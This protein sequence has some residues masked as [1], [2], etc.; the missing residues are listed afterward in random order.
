[1]R[2]PH[3]ILSAFIMLA[4]GWATLTLGMSVTT[5]VAQLMMVFFMSTLG[6]YAV[7]SAIMYRSSHLLV[8]L[9]NNI[10]DEECRRDTHVLRDYLHIM[11]GVAIVSV[12]LL[13]TFEG[14]RHMAPATVSGV[15]V[16]NLARM[17]E[18][19]LFGLC[20]LNLVYLL[21]LFRSLV[22]GMVQ[23]AMTRDTLD[24]NKRIVEAE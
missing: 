17:M 2:T 24:E 22:Q 8:R 16:L 5:A 21:L 9:H 23:E 11:G 13:L 15:M 10:N 14:C 7:F 12:L 1:M 3:R 19:G 20:G 4:A 6:L 18:A